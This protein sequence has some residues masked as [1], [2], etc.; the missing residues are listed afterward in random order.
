MQS[1][2]NQASRMSPVPKTSFLRKLRIIP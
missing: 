1:N 2:N